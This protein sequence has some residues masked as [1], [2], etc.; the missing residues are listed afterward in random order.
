MPLLHAFA[1]KNELGLFI[2]HLY[3][4]NFAPINSSICFRAEVT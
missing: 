1:Q 3:P 4:K 2:A